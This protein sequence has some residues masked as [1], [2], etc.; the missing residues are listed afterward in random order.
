M[1]EKPDW[2]RTI[3]TSTAM[4]PIEPQMMK[5]R[6]SKEEILEKSVKE[7]SLRHVRFGVARFGNKGSKM[8]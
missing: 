6:S 5:P 1:T 4:W 7:L 2:E 8:R 3:M